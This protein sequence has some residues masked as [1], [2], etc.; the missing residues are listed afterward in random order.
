MTGWSGGGLLDVAGELER[1]LHLG[2]DL[3]AGADL[4]G[5]DP[6][7]LRG[8]QGRGLA[9]EFLLGGRAAGVPDPDRP[10]GVLRQ[11]HGPGRGAGLPRPAGAAVAGHRHFQLLP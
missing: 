8:L 6:L 4:L 7:A 3:D 11:G 9:G 5:E 2:A 1:V 10:G